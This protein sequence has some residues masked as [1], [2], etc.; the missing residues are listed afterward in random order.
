MPSKQT[1]PSVPASASLQTSRN[2]RSGVLGLHHVSVTTAD[3]DRSLN[4]YSDLL[5]LRLRGK[6]ESNALEMSMITGFEGTHFKWAELDL[7]NS[8]MLELLEYLTPRGE[9]VSQRTADP[10]SG[11]IAIAVEN[12]GEIHRRLVQH[13]ITVR[14]EPVVIEEPGDWEGT[15]TVY[16]VDPDGFTIE[17]LEQPVARS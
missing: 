7:G 17:L 12:I 11:H 8:Q 4:F 14:S 1:G 10:G 16:V 15:T 2:G 9:R 5:G 6:G 3:L 13:G